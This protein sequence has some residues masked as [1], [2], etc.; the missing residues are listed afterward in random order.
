MRSNRPRHL[1]AK[2]LPLTVTITLLF[3]GLVLPIL[4]PQLT[5]AQNEGNQ[6]ITTTQEEVPR[7]IETTRDFNILSE[8]NSNNH[9]VIPLLVPGTFQVVGQRW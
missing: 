5:Y 6:A 7:R 8:P 2:L 1:S 4:I 3:L 9:S